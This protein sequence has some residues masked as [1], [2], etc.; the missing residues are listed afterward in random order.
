MHFPGEYKLANPVWHALQETHKR[1]SIQYGKMAFYRA[2][3][4]PFGGFAENAD[5]VSAMNAYAETSNGF[6][7]V[8]EKPVHANNI[9][10][11]RVLPCYQMLLPEFHPAFIKEKVIVLEPEQ[12]PALQALVNRVQPGYFTAQ[13]PL[14][15]KYYGIYQNGELVAASGERMQT[16]ECIEISAVVTDPQHTGRGYASQLVTYT[17]EQIYRQGKMPF[18][19][20]AQAN[21][22]AIKVYE[23]IGFRVCREMDFWNF[24][25]ER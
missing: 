3:Y 2:E 17:A 6:F 8:G 23:K 10:L 19:H 9:V 16:D 21:T 20:V 25:R 14:L 4:C 7:V 1:L 13:T 12:W 15:G 18:L 22:V 5:T 24:E 11:K